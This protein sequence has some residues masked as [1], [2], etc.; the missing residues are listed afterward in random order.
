MSNTL[1][2]HIGMQKTGTTALQ[3]FLLN[4][5]DLLQK[6]GWCYPILCD[7]EL[8]P[9]DVREIQGC[10]NAYTIYCALIS[11]NSRTEWNAGMDIVLRHLQ[12]ENVV[13][14]AEEI[15]LEGTDQFITAVK[16]IYENVK[17]VV[18]LRRQDREIE[19][20]YNQVIKSEAECGTF[21]QFVKSDSKFRYHCDG[22]LSK[23]EA[24][25]R[26]IGKENLIVR[27]YEKQQLVGNDITTDFLSVLGISTDRNEWKRSQNVNFSMGGNQ[28]EIKKLINS[29][30]D[31]EGLF[32]D[33]KNAWIDRDVQADFL[34]IFM[35]LAHSANKNGGEYGFFSSD[36]RKEFLKGYTLENERIAREYMHREDGILFYDDK[37]DYPMFTADRFSDFQAETIRSF[38]AM[39]YLQNRRMRILLEKKS[40]EIMGKVLKKDIWSKS[41]GRK[42][43]LYGAGR[44]CKRLLGIIG[45]IFSDAAIADNDIAKR[46]MSLGSMQVQYAKDIGDWQQ[47]FVV[48]TCYQTDEIEKQLCGLGLNKEDHYILTK[49]YGL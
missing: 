38:T 33:S 36:E 31:I 32:D 13:I 43:M 28:L 21:D 29:V 23:L 27:V 34:D 9:S 11:W 18:Y 47:Y 40:E 5:N 4:N 6:Y 24:I 42:L 1:L 3:N 37:M 25:S 17:V 2:I 15:S 45:D 49:E 35:G 10:G 44:N 41:K 8:K 48:V 14:S 7:E 39:V 12:D 19:S 20:M 46:G 26:I 22:Y 30:Y 16:S